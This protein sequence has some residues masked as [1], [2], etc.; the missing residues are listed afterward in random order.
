MRLLY[1]D[2]PAFALFDMLDAFRSLGIQCDA[3]SH[4]DYEDRQ[5]KE[6]ESA[7]DIAVSKFQ[8]DFAFS[9]NYF[10]ILSNCCQRHGIPY[11]SYVYDSPLVS[12]FSY[13]LINPC[14]RVFLFDKATY[15][16]FHDDGITTVHYLPLAA[17]IERISSLKC[18]ADLKSKLHSEVSFVGALYNEDHNLF[19]R[20]DKISPYTRGYLDAVM[21]AQQLVY[22]NFFLEDV[23]TS[24]ILDDIQRSLPYSPMLDGVESDAYVYANY[25][26][27]RKITSKERLF[28]LKKA[29]ENFQL[30]LY[31]NQPS[32]ELP[33]AIFM[34]T[35]DPYQVA[36]LVYQNSLVNLNISLRS[37][38]TGIPLRCM[39]IMGSGGFLLTNYQED[40]LDYFVP[41]E[42]FAYYEDADD[43]ILKINHYLHHDLERIQIARNALD[44]MS[45]SH[46]YQNRARTILSAL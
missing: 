38:Q 16:R 43:L 15:R 27:A 35:A 44:K 9:F 42:D 14:N 22:G 29:S 37:I 23:L 33:K 41:G 32:A 8:Y 21:N 5:N 12:L 11:V 36:P 28:L 34:G 10:P 19:E 6:F 17:N 20:L 30:K 7:F 31:S 24:D 39:E 46:T 40:L 18:T 25:F 3:F 13:S 2:S 4:P 1:L 45:E 26:L